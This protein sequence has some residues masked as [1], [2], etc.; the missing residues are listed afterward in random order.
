MQSFEFGS[1][2]VL[3]DISKI[4]GFKIEDLKYFLSNSN[5]NLISNDD[6]IEKNFLKIKISEK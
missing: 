4:I 6:L 1:D 5:L 3:K 2:L